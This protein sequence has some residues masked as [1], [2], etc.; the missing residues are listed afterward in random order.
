MHVRIDPRFVAGVV[1]VVASVMGVW[2]FI[3]HATRGVTIYTAKHTI[4]VGDPVT[5][6]ELTPVHVR[7]GA[8]AEHY[9]TPERLPKP[10]M[11]AS[12]TIMAGE[13]VSRSALTSVVQS[14]S[15]RVVVTVAGPLPSV[16]KPG[17]SV[18][19]WAAATGAA[20][21]RVQPHVIAHDALVSAV[22]KRD[23]IVASDTLS[24]EVQVDTTEVGALLE[25]V[26]D[27]DI[28]SLVT[29]AAKGV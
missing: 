1:L 20:A 8:S 7:I 2:F 22:M 24:V 19:V 18:D 6:A 26:A 23:G 17:R 25:A 3:D 5:S 14:R 11:R 15:D 21:E 9:L 27:G 12:A 16:V 29:D 13:F 10:G 4:I 28:I